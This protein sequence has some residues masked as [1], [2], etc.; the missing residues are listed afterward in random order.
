MNPLSRSL[1]KV[2]MANHS[3]ARLRLLEMGLILLISMPV[4]AEWVGDA[5][6]MMGTEVSVWLWH[7]NAEAGR[8]LVDAVFDEAE[9]INQLMSCSG[10]C[11]RG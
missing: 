9:R 7:D 2:N 8:L 3:V 10:P 5:R 1:P 11:G 6:P 4:S